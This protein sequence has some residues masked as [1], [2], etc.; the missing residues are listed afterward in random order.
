M[1]SRDEMVDL[2]SLCTRRDASDAHGA[3]SRR[4][5]RSALE[6]TGTQLFV[7]SFLFSSVSGTVRSSVACSH[8][9]DHVSWLRLLAK[10]RPGSD[11]LV[12]HWPQND[13]YSYL[14]PGQNKTLRECAKSADN[15]VSRVL[16]LALLV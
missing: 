1:I 10:D 7:L 13:A 6:Q 9:A 5:D 12:T 11:L 14:A 3:V 15:A 4:P 2:L 16:L 8:W